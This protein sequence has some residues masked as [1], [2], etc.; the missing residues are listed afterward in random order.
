MADQ[1]VETCIQHAT[2]IGMASEGKINASY[3]LHCLLREFQK[4]EVVS[5]D[6]NPVYD[7]ED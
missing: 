6:K 5:L 1:L 2:P 7:Y 4:Q 3:F